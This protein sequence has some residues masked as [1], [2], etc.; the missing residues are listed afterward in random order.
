VVNTLNPDKSWSFAISY[1]TMMRWELRVTSAETQD[2]V[3]IAA[4]GR[5]SAATAV[6]R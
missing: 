4:A 5:L 6:S 3:R 1:S 2:G